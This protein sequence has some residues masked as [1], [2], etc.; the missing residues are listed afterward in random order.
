MLLPQK[1]SSRHAVNLRCWLVHPRIACVHVPLPLRQNRVPLELDRGS[2]VR[3]CA[4]FD[5]R[6]DR[7]PKACHRVEID[8]QTTMRQRLQ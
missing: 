1:G 2:L 6:G 3:D 8:R 7:V 5:S 4:R